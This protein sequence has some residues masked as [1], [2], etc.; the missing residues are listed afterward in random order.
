MRKIVLGVL[1]ALLFGSAE[2]LAQGTPMQNYCQQTTTGLN[3]WGP[4][5]GNN[6]LAIGGGFTQTARAPDLTA[7]TSSSRV[8]LGATA[9]TARVCN[10]GTVNAYVALGDVTVNATLTGSILVTAGNCVNLNLGTATYLA[11]ITASSSVTIQTSIGNGFAALG[12]GGSSGGGGGTSPG[13]A[14][15]EVQYND[16]GA[17]GGIIGATTDGTT[18]TLVAPILGTPTSATLTNATGLPISTGVF[19]LGTGVATA[20]GNTA[21]GAGGFALVGTTPPTGACGGDLTGTFPNCTLAWISRSASQTLNIGAGGTLGALSFVTPGTGVATAAAVNIGSAGAFVTFNGAGGTPS[22]MVGTNITGTAAGLTAGTV[23]T[24]ANLTGVITSSGNS[25]SITSQTGTGTKFVVDTNPALIG[26]TLGVAAGTSLALG[27]ATIGTDALGIT[28][29]ATLSGQLNAASFVPT[30]STVPVNGLYLSGA[31]TVSLSTNS[32]QRF[33][34]GT[35]SAFI[36]VRFTGVANSWS[37]SPSAASATSPSFSPNTADTTT[38]IGAQAS[39]NISLIV[40]GAEKGRWTSTGLAITGIGSTTS[41]FRIS[42][43]FT[44]ATLPVAGT[45]GRFAYVTDQLTTCAAAGAALVGGGAV[46]CP[47]FDNGVAWVGG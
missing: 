32:G 28:G 47:V 8:A 10:T 20:L 45:A 25:T 17:F 36:N 13:G 39:G 6:P 41:T 37:L 1:L 30:G 34:L 12:G 24:N 33:A 19:G 11:G 21:G 2:A 42:T 27:G 15:T 14:N 46:T 22:S 43:G 4:C 40:S 38:G 5:S 3:Q 31:N 18:L 7:T 44:V 26:P 29:T 9:Q 23:T 35:S 16:S